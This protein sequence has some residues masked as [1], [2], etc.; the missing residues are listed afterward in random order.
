MTTFFF[1]FKRLPTS[2]CFY[3]WKKKDGEYL[4][5]ALI[6]LTYDVG[7]AFNMGTLDCIVCL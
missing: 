2:L 5:E 4:Q 7:A 1:F 6:F 3:F